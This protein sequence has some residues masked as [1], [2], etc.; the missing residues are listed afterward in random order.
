MRRSPVTTKR[1][2]APASTGHQVCAQ[3]A[4]CSTAARSW[5]WPTAPAVRAP[6]SI[7]PKGARGTTTVESK[8][9]FLRGV[10]EGYIEAVSRP[11]HIGRTVVVVETDVRDPGDRLVAGS[12]RPSSSYRL[13]TQAN[14]S[15]GTARLRSGPARTRASRRPSRARTPCPRS[16]TVTAEQRQPFGQ[17]HGEPRPRRRP[18]EL[19]SGSSRPGAPAAPASRRWPAASAGAAGHPHHE[20]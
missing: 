20:A 7:S 12:P 6:S 3:S 19:T 18:V 16:S 4:V 1:R 5:H 14:R 8:T 13:I 2:C 9:N 15:P 17:R 10:R 11:L